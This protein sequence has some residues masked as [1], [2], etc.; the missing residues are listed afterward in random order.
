MWDRL[1]SLEFGGAKVQLRI[2]E[3][4]RDRAAEAEA[5]GDMAVAE[6]LRA[7]SSTRDPR[8]SSTTAFTSPS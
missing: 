1:E 8:S 2:I 4:L 6:A 3:R 5:R 7:R